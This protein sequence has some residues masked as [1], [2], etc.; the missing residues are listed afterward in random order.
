M[1]YLQADQIETYEFI[2]S[3]SRRSGLRS[4]TLMGPDSAKNLS[5]FYGEGGLSGPEHLELFNRCGL[6]HKGGV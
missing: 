4:I 2:N 5:W 6:I 1:F 3:A